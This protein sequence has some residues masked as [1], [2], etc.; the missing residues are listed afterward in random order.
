MSGSSAA[1]A[2]FRQPGT[3]ASRSQTTGRSVL[4]VRDDSHVI[5]LIVQKMAIV[6]SRELRQR[7]TGLG[8][9]GRSSEPGRHPLDVVTASYSAGEDWE[10]LAILTADAL[11]AAAEAAIAGDPAA[12]RRVLR[13]SSARKA[14]KISA[15]ARVRTGLA[16]CPP[17]TGNLRAVASTLQLIADLGH[18]GDLVDVL[19]RQTAAT[20]RP[21]AVP[22]LLRHDVSTVGRVGAHRIRR[23]AEGLHGPA[24]DPDYLHDGCELRG[25]VDHLTGL[26]GSRSVAPRA[27]RVVRTGTVCRALAESLLTASR[28]AG[29]AA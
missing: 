21:R 5:D 1:L 11:E 4:E 17:R 19:A 28:H 18:V 7:P 3:L 20:T 25:V 6:T 16:Q 9:G 29:R 14:A 22:Q 23:L 15:E 12:A 13:R 26:A 10:R 2:D 24:M 27:D 8:I